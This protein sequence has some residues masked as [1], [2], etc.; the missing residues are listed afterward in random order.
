M[1]IEVARRRFTVVEYHRMG[2]AGI[3]REGDRVELIDGEIVEMTPIGSRHASCVKRLNQL[4]VRA[5]GDRAVVSV[6]DPIAIPPESEP[7]PD[8]ALLRPRADFYA[9]GHPGPADVLLV[10]EVA[11]TSAPFDR[12]VK[13]P[14]YARAGITEVWLVDLTTDTV[15]VLR[16]SSG[17]RLADV[18]RHGRAG[19]VACEAFPDL[20]LSID[21]L[22]GP[23]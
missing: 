15:E 11:D 13:I 21:E 7:Q 9:G 20:D 14:L 16:R 22:L 12:G 2:E 4:F 6:Q 23:P 1:A 19:R 8:L 5:L 17:G 10:V 18:Q 3:L